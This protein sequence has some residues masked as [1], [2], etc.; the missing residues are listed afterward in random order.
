M[1]SRLSL[2]IAISGMVTVSTSVTSL[3]TKKSIPEKQ[4]DFDTCQTNGGSFEE[5][6][7]I[8]GGTYSKDKVVTS[9]ESCV[10]EKEVLHHA[11]KVNPGT[12]NIQKEK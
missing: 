12:I 10:I 9:G 5:C 4:K 1:W 3:A 11:L 2:I 8:A 6:C 7:I